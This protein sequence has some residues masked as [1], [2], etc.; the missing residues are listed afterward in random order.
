MTFRIGVFGAGPTALRTMRKTA[1]LHGGDAIALEDSADLPPSVGTVAGPAKAAEAIAEA[2]LQL[3]GR[4]SDL[5]MLL[6][7]AID[8]REGIPL[9]NAAR[10]KDTAERFGAA[11]NLDG[12]ALGVFVRGAL[13][14][15]IGKLE[16]TNGVLL[17]NAMLTHDEWEALRAHTTKGEA[18]AAAL[19]GLAD[20][21]PLVRAHHECWD[22]TGYPDG[23]EGDEI[24]LLARAMKIVDVYCSMT[25]PRHY[26][27]GMASPDE[28]FAHIE[29]ES[30]K[31]FDP[32][33]APLFLQTFR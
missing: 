23:K 21:A 27:T 29:E 12:E 15:D 28:A 10:V 6:A 11:M 25:G 31:H 16:L 17:T 4:Q 33:L 14:H 2:A 8:A 1:Q 32:R 5:L 20:I 26:R 3:A 30:G 7:Q 22:G 18:L 13:L 24:P 19:P 9:A